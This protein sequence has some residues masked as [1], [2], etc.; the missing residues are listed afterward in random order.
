MLLYNVPFGIDVGIFLSKFWRG[1]V[2]IDGAAK[3]RYCHPKTAL[4]LQQQGVKEL[5]TL[6]SNLSANHRILSIQ[7][8]TQNAVQQP[9]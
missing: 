7:Q 2:K 4:A 6:A 9:Y 5:L 3:S 8:E 1:I